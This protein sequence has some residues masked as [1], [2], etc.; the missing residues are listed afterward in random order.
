MRRVSSHGLQGWLLAAALHLGLLGW[1]FLGDAPPRA[2]A[3][4][5]PVRVVLIS[6]P[7]PP[8]PPPR[9]EQRPPEPRP[10][11]TDRPAPRRPQL[12]RALANAAPRSSQPTPRAPSLSTQPPPPGTPRF[13]VA[14]SATV[15]GGGVAVPVAPAGSAARAI[16]VPRWADGAP[17]T[18]PPA[19]EGP[20]RSR[21]IDA[22]DASRVPELVAQPDPEALRRAYPERAR[23]AGLEANVVLRILVST[24]GRVQAVRLIKGAGNGFDEAAQRLVREFRFRAGSRDGKAVPVWIPWTYKFRLNG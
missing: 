16:G 18:P 24:E 6:R 23:A 10:A 2:V 1:L 12:R 3:K 21:P 15:P 17:A 14:L 13:Q 5:P 8:V 11:T 20:P 4:R 19:P 22:S 7:R 9:A